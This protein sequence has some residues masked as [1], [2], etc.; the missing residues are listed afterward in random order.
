LVHDLG[1]EQSLLHLR[2]LM[3][4]ATAS[5]GWV[6]LSFGFDAAGDQVF[7]V[8]Y[9]AATKAISV[10]LATGDALAATLPSDLSWHA[11][12]L[13]IDT[14]GGNAAL[15][16]NG[17]SV[18]TASGGFGSLTTRTVWLGGI[19][20]DANASGDLYLDEWVIA[21]AYIGPVLVATS[22]DY[23][24]DPTRWLVV[25]NTADADSVA[26]SEHYRQARGVPFANLLGLNLPT[27]AGAHRH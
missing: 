9:D 11:I 10:N 19:L 4:P 17:V 12:E 20:K 21:Q 6:I 24:D 1:S 22:S 27:A 8:T 2:W 16:I 14:V 13:K 23:A 3:N 18:D 15:W 7:R 25:Y 26:W 5:G